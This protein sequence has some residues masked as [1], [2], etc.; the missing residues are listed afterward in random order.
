MDKFSKFTFYYIT[1]LALGFVTGL[2]VRDTTT[3]RLSRKISMSLVDYYEKI[4]EPVDPAISTSFPD[5]P[6]LLKK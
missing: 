6:R 5:V 3:L 2:C 4:D 1:P